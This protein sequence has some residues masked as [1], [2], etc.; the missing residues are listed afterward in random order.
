MVLA[1]DKLF[2]AGPRDIVDEEEAVYNPND[3][4]IQVKL[5]EQNAMLESSK[6]GLLYVVSASD[7]QKIKEYELESQ[8][9]W[10]GMAAAN[11]RL[12]F[13]TKNGKITCFAG[14]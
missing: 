1:N 3:E 14:K 6:G 5:S 4:N 13:A 9:V 10:D 12:Y 7:G 11:S 8:P 2:I